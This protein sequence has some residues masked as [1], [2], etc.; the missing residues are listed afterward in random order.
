MLRAFQIDVRFNQL[1]RIW[2]TMGDGN[3]EVYSV[4]DIWDVDSVI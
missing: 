1:A 2:N 3:T 4:G